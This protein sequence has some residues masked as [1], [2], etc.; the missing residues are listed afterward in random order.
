MF[1][2]VAV[3][4]SCSAE[5]FG[6]CRPLADRCYGSHYIIDYF[7]SSS[8]LDRKIEMLEII[9]VA[10]IEDRCRLG[11]RL[12]PMSIKSLLLHNRHRY[13]NAC[14]QLFKITP[15]RENN[16]WINTFA[17]FLLRL[18]YSPAPSS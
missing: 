8:R 3:H 10:C 17:G 15:H 11:V 5:H 2:V 13:R 7:V 16:H 9:D 6:W 14:S 12:F 4:E 18:I 1:E